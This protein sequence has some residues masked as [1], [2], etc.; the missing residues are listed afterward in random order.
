MYQ[1]SRKCNDMTCIIS[2]KNITYTFVQGIKQI[3]LIFTLLPIRQTRTASQI[4]I[5]RMGVN[6]RLVCDAF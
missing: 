1:Y 3:S 5:I 6:Y 4:W 2:K